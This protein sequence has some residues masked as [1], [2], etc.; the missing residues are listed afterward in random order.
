MLENNRNKKMTQSERLDHLLDYMKEDSIQYKDLEVGDDYEEKR[1][2]LRSL[3]NIRMH[4]P[5]SSDILEDVYTRQIKVCIVFGLQVVVSIKHSVIWF[6]L[7]G[8]YFHTMF[9]TSN[10]ASEICGKLGIIVP[11]CKYYE[12]NKNI[13]SIGPGNVNSSA[14]MTFIR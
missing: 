1:G 6:V 4:R 9:I 5:L 3:M 2:V 8:A 13:I 12:C 14:E 7:I 10:S 11:P